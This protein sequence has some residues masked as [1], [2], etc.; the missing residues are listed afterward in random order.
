MATYVTWFYTISWDR[1]MRRTP[2]KVKMV[3]MSHCFNEMRAY[4]W[5]QAL[6]FFRHHRHACLISSS[7]SAWRW[8]R[9]SASST[10]K[11]ALCLQCAEGWHESGRACVLRPFGEWGTRYLVAASGASSCQARHDRMVAREE[12]GA[13][14]PGA[15]WGWR[16]VCGTLVLVAGCPH[17]P[18][19]YVCVIFYF[20]FNIVKVWKV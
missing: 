19:V 12:G 17:S 5:G 7:K 13:R 10:H 8:A 16:M 6:I 1:T 18:Q 3:S 2:H 11:L 15:V 14:K 20:K 4:P 9:S